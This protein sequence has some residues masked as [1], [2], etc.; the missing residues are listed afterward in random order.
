MHRPS[1]RSDAPPDLKG[2]ILSFSRMPSLLLLI[3]SILRASISEG[4]VYP[5]GKGR[6]V[7]SAN[8][9]IVS[10]AP[11]ITELLY[12]LGLISNI[13]GVTRYDD[14]PEEIKNREIIGGYL[15]V[16]VEKIIKIKPDIV[17]C[18]PNSGIKSAVDLISKRGIPVYV[19]EVKSVYDILDSI[20]EL[21]RLFNRKSEA[22]DLINIL[23][24]RYT[25][26]QT[27]TIERRRSG[28]IILN[29][30]PI[31]VA[32]NNSFVGELLILSGA[33]NAYSGTHKYP[34]ID[35]EMLRKMK[36]DFVINVSESV[37][38]G[39]ETKQRRISSHIKEILPDAAEFY[40]ISTP[41]FIHPSPRF[42]EA[43]EVLC[44]INSRFYCF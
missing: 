21:G 42:I 39:E 29:E 10:L 38:S 20:D 32:G 15:D 22:V 26:L 34:V 30:I 7:P 1:P 37:M 23:T 44:S 16:D 13:I 27:Y 6:F 14:F 3:I 25:H 5:I 31:M 40:N 41:T 2:G 36:I 28:L 8:T 43:L 17:L 18:E 9:R 35:L 12:F 24:Q 19:I 4:A 11:S 33:I